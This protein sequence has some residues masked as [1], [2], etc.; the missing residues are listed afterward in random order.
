MRPI[1]SVLFLAFLALP[2]P[3]LAQTLVI[4]ENEAGSCYRHAVAQRGDRRAIADCDYALDDLL[5]M[6]RDR[7]ATHI[8]RGIVMMHS[9]DAEAALADFDRA[10]AMDRIA[11]PVLAL[12]RSSALIRLDRPH[13]AME[14][15]AIV[16]AAGG[17]NLA[18]AWFNRAVALEMLG[19][20][21]GAY[22]AYSR[23]AG[24]RSDWPLVQREL[25]RF[26]V[27]TGS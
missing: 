24:L 20:V 6:R 16:I 27:A 13:E 1:V 11:A 10:D 26:T 7:A 5:L 8:N 15:T 18:E 17:D 12:N 22:E 21:T 9:G 23:A 19:D 2:A 4:G 3:A 25:A 14:Q